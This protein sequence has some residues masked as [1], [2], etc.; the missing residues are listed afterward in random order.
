MAGSEGP[1]CDIVTGQC[2]CKIHVTGRSC[3]T[4]E[5]LPEMS[6]L[7]SEYRESVLP[8]VSAIHNNNGYTTNKQN[9]NKEEWSLNYAEIY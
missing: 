7:V 4:C 3:D 1:T 8:S 9:W 2:P 6:Y 5:V